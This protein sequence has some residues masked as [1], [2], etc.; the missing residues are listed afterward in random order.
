MQRLVDFLEFDFANAGFN[1][2]ARVARQLHE[3][4]YIGH[5]FLSREGG[6]RI[7]P[8]YIYELQAALSL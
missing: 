5:G 1:F 7:A 6:R 2:V 4:E 8:P 3:L